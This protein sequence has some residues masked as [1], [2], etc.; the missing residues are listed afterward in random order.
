MKSFIAEALGACLLTI[1]II[2]A[3]NFGPWIGAVITAFVFMFIVYGFSHVSGAHVNPAIT[4]GALSVGKITPM[5]AFF[6]VV[7]QI[8]GASLAIAILYV[9]KIVLP[10]ETAVEWSWRLFTAEVIGTLLFAYGF[11]AV[12]FR[13][14]DSAASGF[15]IGLSIFLGLVI[16]MLILGDSGDISILNP[17]VAFGLSMT[18]V[19]Y[20]LGPVV[21]AILGM[22]L[23]VGLG[24]NSKH[25]ASEVKRNFKA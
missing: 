22:W 14:V 13:K 18:T 25:I 12:M 19:A 17:A 6:Y 1:T 24:E 10:T 9:T 2:L 21:G 15:V 5:R 8:A 7:S 16:G 3:A 20:I 4:I 11:A 23:F